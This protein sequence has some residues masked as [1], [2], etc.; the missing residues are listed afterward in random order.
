MAIYV[1][2]FG[3]EH[4]FDK[5]APNT[6]KMLEGGEIFPADTKDKK[7]LENIKEQ[8]KSKEAAKAFDCFQAKENKKASKKKCVK[9]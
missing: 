6:Q 8:K 2:R 1:N 4:K 7:V 9:K 5:N 3:I